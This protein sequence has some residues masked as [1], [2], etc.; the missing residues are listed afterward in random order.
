MTRAWLVTLT[1]GGRVLRYATESLQVDGRVYRAGLVS[2]LALELGTERDVTVEIVSRDLWRL[3]EHL[4]AGRGVL[5]LLDDDEVLPAVSGLL[6]AP[7]YG[8]LDESIAV[9][10]TRDI[11]G[12]GSRGAPVPDLLARVDEAT[13]PQN[14]VGVEIGTTGG[15]YPVIFG[16]PGWTGSGTPIPCVPIPLAQR[17]P[18]DATNTRMVV[19][20]DSADTVITSVRI[21]RQS[22]GTSN[23]QSVLPATDLLGRRVLAANCVAGG[24]GTIPTAQ[25]T[26][27]CGYSPTGGG[28]AARE[29][30]D[31]IRYLLRRWGRD[32]VDWGR[33]ADSRSVLEG[34]LVDSWVDQQIDDPW[35]LIEH[36]IAL[37]PV[38]QRVSAVGRYLVELRLQTDP[39]RVTADLELLPGQRSGDVIRDGAPVNEIGVR[40]RPDPELGWAAQVLLGG[41]ARAVLPAGIEPSAYAA[42]VTSEVARR[43]V[44]RYGTRRGSTI[45]L[46]WT[47]DTGTALSVGRVQ[48]LRSALPAELVTYRLSVEQGRGLLEGADVL[49]TD[50]QLGWD[51]RPALVER[52]PVQGLDAVTVLLRVPST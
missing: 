28:G 47:W 24:V 27:L 19:S 35:V 7:A 15:V 9:T 6:V 41:D 14:L 17:V 32:S 37:L 38:Q 10:I 13:W 44:A 12:D 3:R 21:R 26:L 31:V 8:A 18:G 22:V 40:Y 52:P 23:T 34:Y 46:D 1:V 16:Y 30:Y 25:E 43:S 29:L 11:P 33:L 5:E 36:L 39:T 4:D 42:V 45:D 51:R 50:E 48:L 20:E 2:S 49:V